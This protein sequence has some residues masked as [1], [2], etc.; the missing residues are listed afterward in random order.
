[1][2]GL[3]HLN[4]FDRSV[5]KRSTMPAKRGAR[6]RAKHEAASKQLHGRRALKSCQN[7]ATTRLIKSTDLHRSNAHR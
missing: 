3:S 6:R 4:R 2:S 5:E 1:M 7:N